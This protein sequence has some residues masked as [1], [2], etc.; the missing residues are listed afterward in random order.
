VAFK[1]KSFVDSV[2]SAFRSIDSEITEDSVEHDFSPRLVKYFIEGVL[3][4]HGSEYAYERGRTDVTLLDENKNRAV[5]IETKRPREDLSAERWQ[6]QA[7]KYADATTRYVGLTNGYRFLL[8][9]VRDGKRLLKADI[10]FRAL[11][12]AKR[13]SEEKLSPAEV[14]QILA[15]ESLK[16]EEIWNAEKYGNFDE[17]YAKIDISEDAGFERLIDRLNYIANDLLR[18]YTYDAFDEYYAGYEQYRREIGEIQTIKREN[19]NRKSAAE[20]AKFELKTEGKYAKY[21]SFKGFHIWKAVSD[22]ES[23]EDDENKQVFCKESI[24]VLLSRLLFI[25]FCEDRGLLKKKISNGGI[26]RLREELEEPLTGSSNIYKSVLQLAY[27]GAKNIY[28]HFYEKNNPLDWYETGDGE[29]DRVL[30]KVLW[31]LNQ[32][33]FSK[34]DRE[35]VGKIYEK[36]LPKDER[37]KLGE[38]YTPDAVIDYILDAAE[39]VPSKAIDGKDLIDPACGSGGFLVRAA[40]RLIARYAVKF[41]KATPKEALDSRR[42]ENVYVRLSPSECE[43]IVRGVATHVHGFDINPFAVSISEMN[44]LFQIIDLYIKAVKGNPRF[45]V[46]RF[47]VYQTDSLELPTDQTSL[48]GYQSPT[49]KSLAQDRVAID[50]L[51]KK[52]YDF[53]VGNPPYVRTHEQENEKAYLKENYAEVMEGQADIFIPFI[54]RGFDFL[55]ENGKISY[56]V[57]N[58][59]LSN[60]YATKTRRFILE[61]SIL[62]QVVDS[63][64]I[65]WFEASVYPI[66]FVIRRT[67]PSDEP[68]LFGRVRNEE[69]LSTKKID[70]VEIRPSQ[71]L[72][73][74]NSVIPAVESEKELRI[75]KKISENELILKVFR[76]KPTSKAVISRAELDKKPDFQK[77]NFV[78]AVSNEDVEPFFVGWRENYI[79]RNV[80]DTPDEPHI[81]MRKLCLR[82]TAAINQEYGAINTTY[83]IQPKKKMSLVFLEAILNSKLINFYANKL[84]FS[85]HM[86]GNYIELR[87]GQ[88]EALPIR[89]PANAEEEKTAHEIEGLAREIHKEKKQGRSAEKLEKQLDNSVYELYGITDEERRTIEKGVD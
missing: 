64:E 74:Y 69:Q 49:G 67:S 35:V 4:Y 50:D 36:Y 89:L 55:K 47:Q 18:Q 27:G 56:I 20:I 75:I 3:D 54:K 61:K 25:R 9:E 86:G 15:L 81:L 73:L 51:K 66:I 78:K 39:Y 22:R 38:F 19:N 10:D 48:V 24:Y 13:V 28:Y 57:S 1:A 14:A 5:V 37:K 59:L 60:D 72:G 71:I 17:Y 43:E 83:V 80:K 23:K 63:S 76:P 84:F 46:P 82:L 33:D 45:Q 58:K 68:I 62:E 70:F 12:K 2:L 8:W 79:D 87:T 85:T 7:G 30:N 11:I 41:E 6:H 88:I 52:K 65:R 16:K 53:V 77:E 26:E 44:L 29:L 21:A 40:R 31:T 42:W 34:G 32:F